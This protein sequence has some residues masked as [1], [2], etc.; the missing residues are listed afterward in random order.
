MADYYPL[1]AH[2]VAGLEKD[3]A[4]NRRTL[5]ERARTALVGQLRGIVPALAESDITRERLALEEA[6]RKVEVEAARRVR[7]KPRPDP[8]ALRRA[9]EAVRREETMDAAPSQ[10]REI[11]AAAL[12]P[13]EAAQIDPAPREHAREGDWQNS[14]HRSLWDE[15]QKEV[16]DVV[17]DAN[18]LGEAAKIAQSA[19]QPFEPA[20]ASPPLPSPHDLA[21]PGYPASLSQSTT[22]SPPSIQS[23][24][25][26]Q[27][28]HPAQPSS[29][30]LPPYPMQDIESYAPQLPLEEEQALLTEHVRP[31]QSFDFSETNFGSSP[32]HSFQQAIDQEQM[33]RSSRSYRTLIWF[34]VVFLLVAG[35][36][37][38]AYW[39]RNAII[40]AIRTITAVVMPTRSPA[41]QLHR[42]TA[43]ARPKI[44]DRIGQSDT[45]QSSASGSQPTQRAV[46]TESDL[47]N[48]GGK[49]YIGSVNWR[50]ETVPAAPGR[51]AELA[52]KLE[53]EIPERGFAMSWLIRRNTDSTLPASHTIDIEFNLAS[54]S[55]LGG[56]AEIKNLLM[57]QPSQIN[58]FPLLGHAQKSTPTY[59]LVGLSGIEI[60]LQRNLQ[61]LKRQPAFEVALVFNNNRRAFLLIEK[62]PAGER[63]F[64]EAFA[65]WKQ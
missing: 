20:P 10:P 60:D 4:E 38:A 16:R 61:L 52:I 31:M 53:V 12:A 19:H 64:A 8:A 13:S 15:A 50:T 9:A 32:S 11:P 62:G 42:D 57:K 21:Q 39:Q 49:N 3:T 26:T 29:S 5:Y 36:G 47:N 22:Q 14:S 7:E 56:V 54:N 45:L 24:P 18:T 37:T 43:P 35:G 63:A 27:P 44:S 51:A 59:F 58:G 55:P 1:I 6:I 33:P 65:A 48:P 41:P 23:S 40:G 46:L 28:S 2:A 25:P 30:I 34:F 17:S